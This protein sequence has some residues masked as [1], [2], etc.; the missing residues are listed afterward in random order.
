MGKKIS[1]N[2]EK[3]SELLFLTCITT[4]NTLTSDRQSDKRTSI[5]TGANKKFVQLH[6]TSLTTHYYKQILWRL[7]MYGLPPGPRTYWTL[8]NER[9]VEISFVHLFTSLFYYI[10]PKIL[11]YPAD[12]QNVKKKKKLMKVNSCKYSLRVEMKWVA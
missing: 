4:T 7:V 3:F 5:W 11:K 9:Q 10:A 2:D 1:N 6:R 8:H 12:T